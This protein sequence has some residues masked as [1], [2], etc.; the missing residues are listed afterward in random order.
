[1]REPPIQ[2]RLLGH[3]ATYGGMFALT[4]FIF[5]QTILHP[6]VWLLAV[7]AIAAM[8]R[9]MAAHN[10]MRDYQLWK[11]EWDSMDDLPRV[12]AARAP[13]AV[14]LLVAIGV[15]AGFVVHEAEVMA[16]LADRG[17][18]LVLLGLLALAAIVW[19]ALRR[20]AQSRRP[21]TGKRERKSDTAIACVAR[22]LLP[23]PG[24]QGAYGA[25]PPHCHAVL[26]N[27]R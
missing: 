17:G 13:H 19:R 7:G 12:R 1:M 2:T 16:P 3:R 5:Y 9:V 27:A 4:L 10:M 23:V 14:A 25:L 22:P 18:P 24:M 8:N 15:P 11:L 21:V 20:P 6:A 26:G